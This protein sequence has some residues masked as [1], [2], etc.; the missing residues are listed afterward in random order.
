MHQ[1]I[2]SRLDSRLVAAWVVDHASKTLP[3]VTCRTLADSVRELVAGAFNGLI[4]DKQGIALLALGSFAVGEPRLTSDVDVLVVTDG[5]E[6]EPITRNLQTLNQILAEG[7]LLKLDF[8][9]RGE[10]AN[11]ANR[12]AQPI[13][14][15]P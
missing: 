14:R 12:L 1:D 8:R 10:G 5:R 15:L 11:A 7:N 6:H 4:G 13:D 3:D 2:R 9:L